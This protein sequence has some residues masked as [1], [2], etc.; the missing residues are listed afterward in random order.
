MID[1]LLTAAFT[2]EAL[3]K[4]IALGMVF[5]KGSFLRYPWNI[6]D[7]FIVITSLVDAIYSAMGKSVSMS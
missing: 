6:I 1:I 7:L 4:M 5:D 2:I 3:L